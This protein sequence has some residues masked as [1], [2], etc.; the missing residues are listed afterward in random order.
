MAKPAVAARATSNKAVRTV[1]PRAAAAT[2][3][4]FMA[5][6]PVIQAKHAKLAAARA[7]QVQARI[8]SN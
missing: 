3:S 1:A 4:T 5:G 2:K 6:K 8:D 7:N